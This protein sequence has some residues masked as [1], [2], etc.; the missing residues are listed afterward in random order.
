TLRDKGVQHILQT[1]RSMYGYA[2]KK[3]FMP[4]YADNPFSGLG[5]RR[6]DIEDAK[7][8]FVYTSVTEVPFF[9]AADDWAFPIHFFLAKTGMRPGEV[10]HLH[11]EDVNLATGWATIR[12]KPQLGWRVKTRRERTVPLIEEVVLVLKRLIGARK[13]GV[14]FLREK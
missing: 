10:A 4:P 13:A 12:N 8:I 2:A 11:I 5:S 7:P 14:L 1:C 9:R 3:R 6:F